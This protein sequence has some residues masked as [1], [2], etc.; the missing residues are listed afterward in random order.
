MTPYQLPAKADL[1]KQRQKIL[2]DALAALVK[3]LK[4]ES[5]VALSVKA[6]GSPYEADGVASQ[7]Y[8]GTAA[9]G[10]GESA[11]ARVK[12]VIYGSGVHA[13]VGLAKD[14]SSLDVDTEADYVFSSIAATE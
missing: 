11:A 2:D 4:D 1:A 3:S 9:K 6:D 14:A 10:K 12:L 8:R 7:E 13:L 5:A